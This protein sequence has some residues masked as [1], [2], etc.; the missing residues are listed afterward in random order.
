MDLSTELRRLL[1][2]DAVIADPA[3]LSVYECD[4]L[5]AYRQPPKV[6]VLPRTAEEVQ[7]I[8]RLCHRLR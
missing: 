5:S 1:P 6:V 7:A 2:R 8:L 4:A 3:S